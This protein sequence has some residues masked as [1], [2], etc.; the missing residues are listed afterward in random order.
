M[1]ALVRHPPVAASGRCYGRTD[2]ELAEPGSA[3][4]L[5][6]R[7]TGMEGIV[8]TSPSGRCRNV[9]EAVGPHRIDP[10]L[11]ELDFGAW[12]G[13]PWDD[14]P[15][16]A[17]DGW[18]ADP[19]GFAPPGGETGAALVS[20]VRDFH[21]DLPPGAHIVVSHGGPL[22]VLLALLAGRPVDLLALPPALGSVT[23]VNSAP[24]PASGRGFYWP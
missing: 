12:E 1:I 7:L 21:A 9:A 20:R 15:R 6:A 4:A 11:M 23:V 22:K 16:S 8:W 18:A 5:A 13:V 19:W 3:A 14:V 17:L 10:R 2:L 24:S